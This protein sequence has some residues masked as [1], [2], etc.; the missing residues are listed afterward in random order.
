MNLSLKPEHLKR[1]KDIAWLFMKYGRSDLV[2]QTGLA[3]TLLDDNQITTGG[4]AKAGE[5]A[6]DLER[7]GPTFIKLGQLLSTRADLLPPPYLEALARLQDK[8]EPFSFAEVEQIVTT[9]LG[10]RLSKA[11]AQFEATPIASASLGQVHRAELRAGRPVVVK[12]QRPGIREIIVADLDA[13][14]ELAAFLDEHTETG[15]RYDFTIMLGEL[16]KSL[17]R[18]LDYREEAA[19]LVTLGESLS[20]F[21]LIVVP[22]PVADYTTSRVLTMDYVRG[23]KVTSLSPLARIEL[24]SWELAQQLFR[25]YLQQM[26]V[27]GFFHADPHPGNV[28][29]TTDQ[30]IALLDIGMVARLTASFQDNMLRLLLAISEGRGDEAAEVTIRMG[31]RKLNFDETKFRREIGDLVVR[32]TGANLQQIDAGQVVLQIQRISAESDFRLPPEFTM[33]AKTLLNLDQVV[34][35]LAPDFDP[36]ATIRRYATEMMQQRILKSLAPGNVMSSLI[37]LK[38]FLEKLPVRINKI[39]DAIANDELKLQVDAI[40]ERILLE[41]LQKVANRIT[42]GL[43]I[44]AMIVGAAMLMRIETTFKIFGYPGLAMIFFL[45]AALAAIWLGIVI[46]FYDKQAKDESKK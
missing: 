20:E 7:L 28:F 39:L 24:N 18:E 22:S 11:F 3:A 9:E 42:L 25:A 27:D 38:D 35:T 45:L 15:R 26:L 2:Q 4:T 29:L 13:L 34:Y 17:L 43:V 41:G 23:K 46:I 32:H 37:D 12:V 10:V 14:G 8:V 31:E 19:N 16:R 44:A 6:D 33:I 40:D 21:E 36:N 1:Y 5:L 30:R